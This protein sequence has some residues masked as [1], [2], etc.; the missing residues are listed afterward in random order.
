[1]SGDARQGGGEPR[2][3][4]RKSG[5]ARAN[6]E[7]GPGL[8]CAAR[9]AAR[10]GA[11]VDGVT[12]VARIFCASSGIGRRSAENAAGSGLREDPGRFRRQGESRSYHFMN[13]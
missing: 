8:N 3:D 1:M 13:P 6:C 11:R 5:E 9:E 2:A 12:L 10:D 4:A 7:S